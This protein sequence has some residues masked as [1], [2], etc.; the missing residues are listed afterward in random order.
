M[1]RSIHKAF[2]G[3]ASALFAC[4]VGAFTFFVIVGVFGLGPAVVG[5]IAAIA[6]VA[7]VSA[8]ANPQEDPQ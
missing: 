7:V 2:G 3:Y 1:P 4:L 6:L 8:R 5:S